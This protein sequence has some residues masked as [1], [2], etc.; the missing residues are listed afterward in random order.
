[1]VE[2][3]G[4][5]SIS[6]ARGAWLAL[7]TRGQELNA[8]ALGDSDTAAAVLRRRGAPGPE[9]REPNS[10]Q[11][12]SRPSTVGCIVAGG[13]FALICFTGDLAFAFLT[14]CTN[15]FAEVPLGPRTPWRVWKSQFPPRSPQVEGPRLAGWRAA[16]P[17]GTPR[18]LGAALGEAGRG[19]TA[20]RWLRGAALPSPP[21]VLLRP[22]GQYPTARHT[23]AQ[24]PAPEPAPGPDY[25]SVSFQSK[26]VLGGPS[27]RHPVRPGVPD[28]CPRT[29]PRSGYP[30]SPLTARFLFRVVSFRFA[31]PVWRYLLWV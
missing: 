27:T 24:T 13:L 31:S 16:H 23:P 25:P 10:T 7:T 15:N 26:I 17:T 28:A 11:G 21:L 2:F 5:R 12:Q 1:M 3:S 18:A 8:E 19:G 9:G 29:S 6:P 20:G 14:Q 22:A 30:S 4:L